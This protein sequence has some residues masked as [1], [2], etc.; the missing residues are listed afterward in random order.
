MSEEE[1]E[2]YYE[3]NGYWPIIEGKLYVYEDDYVCVMPGDMFHPQDLSGGTVRVRTSV[4]GEVQD[5]PYEDLRW[6]A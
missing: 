5:V 4:G 2:A 1:A 3:R 6:V